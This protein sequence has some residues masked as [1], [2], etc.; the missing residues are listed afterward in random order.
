MFRKIALLSTLIFTLSSASWASVVLLKNG[1]RISGEITDNGTDA[2]KIKTEATGEITINKGL[3]DTVLTDDEAE[4]K[5]EADKK[6]QADAQQQAIDAAK[7]QA[8]A[9]TK[10]QDQAAAAAQAAP[11]VVPAPAPKAWVSTVNAGYNTTNGNTKTVGATFEEK[12]TYTHGKNVYD[13]KS[14]M[15][16]DASHGRMSTQKA[17]GKIENDFTLGGP[18]SKWF[19]TRSLEVDHDKFAFVSYRILPQIGIGYWFWKGDDANFETDDGIG[20]EYTHYNTPNT[21]PTGNMADILHL[22][23]DKTVFWKI[24]LSQD[25]TFY[26]NLAFGSEYRFR[27]ESDVVT[28]VTDALAWKIGFIDEYNTTPSGNAKKNDTSLM[29]SIQYAF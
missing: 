12:T 11:A 10:A 25:L 24:K 2:I 19:N 18:G 1:D 6:A 27:S 17:Y 23:I 15:E 26:P 5:K 14:F 21:K 29:T 9:E 28:P 7:A 8:I 20:Y 4:A 22:Y 3:V 16:Y 13:I